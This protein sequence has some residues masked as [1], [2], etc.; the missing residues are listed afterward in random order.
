MKLTWLLLLCLVVTAV[1][2]KVESD[3]SDEEYETIDVTQEGGQQE[4]LTNPCNNHKCKRGEVC[5][6]NE[7]KP[8]CVCQTCDDKV[9][10]ENKLPVCST[11]NV[12]Y[13][14]ECH[15]DR[16]HC[17]CKNRD[18]ACLDN[19]QDKVRLDYYHS[20]KELTEC[21]PE[22]MTMFPFRMRDWLYRVMTDMAMRGYEEVDEYRDLLEN[23]RH[24][25]EH[26]DAVIWK[27]CDLDV[28]PNDRHVTRR[29]LLYIIASLKHMEHCLVPFM[30]NCDANNDNRI[31]LIEWGEC[32]GIGHEA[33]VDKC[34]HHEG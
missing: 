28:H 17:L 19:T 7:R 14:S 33:I 16:D 5:E 25:K 31:T 11:K 8:R 20:C 21:K 34:K 24:D 26:A 22:E 3:D 32:L 15:L 29:E 18:A 27:F 23:A 6:L 1:V 12:T 10:E 9:E 2:A 30:N 4:K 13:I